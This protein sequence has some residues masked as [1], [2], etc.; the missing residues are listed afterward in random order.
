MSPHPEN[1]DLDVLIGTWRTQGDVFGEDGETPIARVDGYDHYGWLGRAFVIHR[2]DVEMRGE[3]VQG[4]EVIGPYLPDRRAFAT[5]AYDHLGGE[6]TSS[7]TLDDEGVWT[8]RADGAEAKLTFSE[9]RAAARADWIRTD[10]GGATWRR[11]MHLTLS[12]IT[13]TIGSTVDSTPRPDSLP[14]GPLTITPS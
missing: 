6:Q 4:L 5:R 14:F 11:W 3:R 12:R 1:A 10:D 2:I 7:A 8:F 9:D 13:P